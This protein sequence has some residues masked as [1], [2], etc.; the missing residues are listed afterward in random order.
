[1]KDEGDYVMVRIN[2]VGKA[3]DYLQKNNKNICNLNTQNFKNIKSIS[4]EKA[5]DSC[6]K[7]IVETK[8]R[9]VFESLFDQNGKIKNV[10]VIQKPFF[11]GYSNSFL[12]YKNFEYKEEPR[13]SKLLNKVIEKFKKLI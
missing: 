13:F 1:M 12:F 7:K 11:S 10:Y 8:D 3:F 2:N 6:V 4:Y 9:K 5:M